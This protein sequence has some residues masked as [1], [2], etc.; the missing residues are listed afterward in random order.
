MRT[1]LAFLLCAATACGRPDKPLENPLE[2][3]PSNLVRLY[4]DTP[5][6]A[7]DS[8]TGRRIRCRLTPGTYRVVPGG[9]GWVTGF[10]DL[11]AVFFACDPPTGVL[12]T[13]TLE[14]V[15]SCAGITHDGHRRGPGV[16][17]FIMVV[18]SI[19]LR[20]PGES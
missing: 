14:V 20:L 13:D 4:R 6:L 7:A 15:G 16:D 11:P 19:V 18:E 12:P 1:I 9:V 2:V 3:S 5:N 10:Q 17:W 8:F